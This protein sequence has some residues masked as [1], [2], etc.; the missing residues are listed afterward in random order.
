M[1]APAAAAVEPSL[2]I[3][4]DDASDP[5]D[6]RPPRGT[7]PVC[8]S[9]RLRYVFSPHGHRVV[10]CAD[11][12]LMFLNPQP[13]DAELAAIY[14]DDYF[15]GDDTA[16]GRDAV[17]R[18]KSATARHYLD[19]LGRYCGGH[20]GGTLLEV[21]CGQGHLLAEARRLGYDVTGVDLSPSAVDAAGRLLGDGGRVLCGQ[22]EELRLPPGSFDA[23]VLADVIEHV[24]DPVG[25]LQ[26]VRRL[27]VPDGALLIATP[28]LVSWSARLLRQDWMEWKPEHLTYFD[29]NTVQNALFKAGYRGAVV[30]PARKALT[31]EYVARHFQ[32]YPVPVFSRAVNALAR[33][34]PTSLRRRNVWVVPSGIVVLA[35]AA[36]VE[37]LP[38][39][40][41]SIVV[42]AYNEA[43]T[44]DALMRS[45]LRKQLPAG[46]DAEVIIVES[47]STDGTRQLAERYAM[48]PR[49][50]LVLEDRPRGKGRAVRMGLAHAT[51]DFV[52]IQDADLEYDLEDY[53]ALL[54]PLVQGCEAFVL[55]SRHGGGGSVWKM[56]RFAHQRLLSAFLNAGHWFF[57]TLLNVMFRQR[58]R[59][60][61]SMY[62]VFRRDCL[63]GLTFSCDRFDFDF[64][65]LIKL[66][67][68]GYRPLEI[69]VNYRS[70]SFR[71]GKKV[72]VW[73]DPLT[74]VR[75][76]V[77][78]RLARIDPLGEAARGAALR[79]DVPSRPEQSKRAASAA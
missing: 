18:M 62:K 35:Q 63:F 4:P 64:E 76:L 23:C 40:K 3:A 61:F 14:G 52:L 39:K 21:G 74:W 31:L 78:L 72:S 28:S 8:E 46:L 58:L 22:L 10:R 30:C 44:F 55:G 57:T 25:F 70:R 45:L 1:S 15:L 53:D 20:R 47:N 19:L 65:L 12:R 24:R 59:D 42:P 71:E 49:V 37:T 79:A 69:P 60:P 50:K 56:R 77:R 9:R 68:K 32:R 75:A 36:N 48:H 66:L 27:L 7:C 5:A 38:A 26:T 41:L 6:V 43:A 13:S 17:A 51:G 33:V 2:R 34:V 73:R 54:E 67:R 29:R 11:C 16:A